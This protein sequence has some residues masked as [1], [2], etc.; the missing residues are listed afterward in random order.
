ML[1]SARHE[2]RNLRSGAGTFSPAPTSLLKGRLVD[3][4]PRSTSVPSQKSIP[5][6]TEL[7]QS[8]MIRSK[9]SPNGAQKAFSDLALASWQASRGVPLVC[10]RT[11]FVALAELRR[12]APWLTLEQFAAAWEAFMASADPFHCKQGHP[13]RWFCRNVNPFLGWRRPVNWATHVGCAGCESCD[14][15]G[16]RRE[17]L[18]SQP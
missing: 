6:K 17:E 16:R 5:G 15:D 4:D 12:G 18:K 3:N 10:D 1:G 14:P 2:F 7:G 8:P 13:L 11:D 9:P